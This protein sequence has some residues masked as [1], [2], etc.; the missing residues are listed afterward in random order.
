VFRLDEVKDALIEIGIQAITLSDVMGFGRQKG[1]TDFSKMKME[2]IVAD[3]L[4]PRVLDAIQRS[5]QSVSRI[6]YS[7]IFITDVGVAI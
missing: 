5:T 1:Y 7:Q 6:C 3:T 4:V 2:I